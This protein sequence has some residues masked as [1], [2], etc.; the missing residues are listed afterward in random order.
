[1]VMHT[2]QS[3]NEMQ[4]HSIS[5]RSSGRLIGLVPTMGSLHEG[6]LS[7]IDIAKDSLLS[8]KYKLVFS[9]ALRNVIND[10]FFLR[11]ALGGEG[12]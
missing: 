1:M 5:L 7:L 4:S 10:L 8:L 3:I 12:Y 2:I 11:Y 9:E 6:H